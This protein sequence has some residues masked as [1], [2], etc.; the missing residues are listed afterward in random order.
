MPSSTSSVSDLKKALRDVAD[1]LARREGQRDMLQ[2]TLDKT[3]QDIMTTDSRLDYMKLIEI[4]LTQFAD[5][6]QASVYKQIEA[7]VSDGLRTVFGEDIRLS[8]SNKVVGARTETVFT[9]ISETSE[10]TLETSIMEAR[11]GGVAAIVGF[12]IQAVLVLLTPGIRPILFLD[13][14]FRNVSEEYQE[15][16]S[17]FIR[18]LCD[19]TGLQVVLVTHQPSIAEHATNWYSFKQQDGQ[20]TISK[21][22]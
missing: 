3:T 16:L 6:R 21:E 7:T 4:F 2:T 12:L 1:S 18:D 11:G 19:R 10:G 17:Q 14:S 15:P 13:E 22:L 9:L 20:T 5:E 8:I